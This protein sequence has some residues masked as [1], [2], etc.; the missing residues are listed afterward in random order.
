[1]LIDAIVRMTAPPRAVVL[2]GVMRDELCAQVVRP[3]LQ[4]SVA[5]HGWVNDPGA[6][7]AGASVQACPSRDE[8]FSQ[9]AVLAM[10][11]GVP[12]VGTSVDGFPKTLDDG[13]GIIVAPE[14][15]A[16]LATALERVL[17]GGSRPDTTSARA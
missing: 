2:G 12:V 9:T 13:R 17:A 16:A 3:G 10:G 6:W 11:L 15:P 8:A 7:V 5:F 1:M 14:D 4:R